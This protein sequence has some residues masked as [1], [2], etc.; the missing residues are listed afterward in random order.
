ME[1]WNNS[2]GVDPV[3]EQETT[4][5]DRMG[6]IWNFPEAITK[7]TNEELIERLQK[8]IEYLKQE[9]SN[10]TTKDDEG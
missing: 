9:D 6:W 10:K 5:A 7:R 2:L 4:A 1:L 3:F 8:R